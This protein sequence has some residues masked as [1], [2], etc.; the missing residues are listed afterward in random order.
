M[1]DVLGLT[2]ASTVRLAAAVG[3]AS[4]LGE[5]FL[6]CV[7]AALAIVFLVAIRPIEDRFGRKTR[8]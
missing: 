3:T 6:A 8:K 7:G 1:H 4:G 5:Y 2:T